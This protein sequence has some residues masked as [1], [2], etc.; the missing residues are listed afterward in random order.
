MGSNKTWPMPSSFYVHERSPK[1]AEQRLWARLRGTQEE[2]GNRAHKG[3]TRESAR[4]L[5]FGRISAATQADSPPLKRVAD[6]G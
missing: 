1:G 2:I 6:W 5:H 4:L 3:S